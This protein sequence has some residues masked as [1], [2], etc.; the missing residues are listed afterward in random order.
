LA[1]CLGRAIHRPIGKCWSDM[2][3]PDGACKFLSRCSGVTILIV[4]HSHC[5]RRFTKFGS[6]SNL[7]HAGK[8]HCF[9]PALLRR[10]LLNRIGTLC[11]LRSETPT[12]VRVVVF[13]PEVTSTD[14]ARHARRANSYVQF[15]TSSKPFSC[16]TIPMKLQ[17][18]LP[19]GPRS[20][21]SC[22]TSIAG[23]QGQV[24]GRKVVA[25]P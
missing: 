6:Q 3:R 7:C 9:G 19:A 1:K 15:R 12:Q 25:L 20:E 24:A 18:T 14:A 5:Q 11:A 13:D 16:H 4:S 17:G 10:I 8:L 23:E 21:S 2:A 22:P